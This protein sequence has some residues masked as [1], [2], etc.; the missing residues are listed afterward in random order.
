VIEK[1]KYHGINISDKILFEKIFT[2][3]DLY[4][5][6]YS[7]KGSIYGI[8]SNSMMTAFKRQA[9]RSGRIKNLYFA[10]GSSHPGG[11]IPLVILSGKHV[12]EIIKRKSIN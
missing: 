12:S 11:G 7:N 2:P 6:Y 5:M 3:D 8:S 10:G 1:L 9:N 4:K